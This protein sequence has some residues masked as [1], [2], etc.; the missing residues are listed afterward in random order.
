[1]SLPADEPLRLRAVAG[2]EAAFDSLVRPLIE[3]GLRLALS[4]LGNRRDAE[5]ATQ[6]A[7]TRAWRKLHQLRPG[8]P[9]RPWFFAI[10]ANQCRNMRRTPWFRFT[11]LVE[12]VG[13]QPAPE[14]EAEH[15]DLERG[16]QRLPAADRGALFLHFYLDLPI[17][18]V[19]ATLG[20]SP[21]AAK[22]RIYR[23]CHRL[24]PAIALEELG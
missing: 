7:L 11:S 3:P 6:E 14:P 1:M 4:M 22:S 10:V 5:D 8:M 17:E 21:A 13:R 2:D 16:L 15:L 12:N 23:A 19:A 24:R 20:V 18:E 9:V